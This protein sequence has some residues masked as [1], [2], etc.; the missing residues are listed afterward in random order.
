MTVV[1]PGKG[2]VWCK[3]FGRTKN[4]LRKEGPVRQL[5]FDLSDSHFPRREISVFV[6]VSFSDRQS[7]GISH[8][9]VTD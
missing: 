7:I 8:R 6:C 1:P 9:F 3:V 4:R 2:S 5:S